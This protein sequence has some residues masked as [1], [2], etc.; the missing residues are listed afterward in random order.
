MEDIQHT[1]LYQQ[2][3]T[4][5]VLAQFDL[6]KMYDYNDLYEEAFPWYEKS[7]IGG[8]PDGMVAL[9]YYYLWGRYVSKDIEKALN[10]FRK[11]AEVGSYNAQKELIYNEALGKSLTK[12][13]KIH[14]VLAAIENTELEEYEYNPAEAKR[15][16]REYIS[17]LRNY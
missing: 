16:L 4:G 6:A 17:F 10:W 7:A 14:Y 1:A 13:E 11:A 2:A 15:N 9:G 5:D 8:C 12:S 3:L